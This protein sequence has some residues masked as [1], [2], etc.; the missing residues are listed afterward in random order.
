MQLIWITLHYD[1]VIS[2][3]TCDFAKNFLLSAWQLPHPPHIDLAV[4]AVGSSPRDV[5]NRLIAWSNLGAG[6]LPLFVAG[7]AVRHSLLPAAQNEDRGSPLVPM[8]SPAMATEQLPV[9]HT[10][11]L[12]LSAPEGKVIPGGGARRCF[13]DP[14]NIRMSIILTYRGMPPAV[15]LYP[16]PAGGSGRPPVIGRGTQMFILLWPGLL[17]SLASPYNTLLSC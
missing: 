17:P 14:T 2:E 9:E 16:S 6:L 3:S 12:H 11:L 10:P 7:T 15:L 5:A 4:S 13:L 8:Q 1:M